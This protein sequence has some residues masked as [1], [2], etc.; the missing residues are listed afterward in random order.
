M[1]CAFFHAQVGAGD[2]SKSGGGGLDIAN[3]LKPALA[4]GDFQVNIQTLVLNLC[5][6]MV[7]KT[8]C[9]PSLSLFWIL[10]ALRA[11]AVMCIALLEPLKRKEKTPLVV[12]MT[13]PA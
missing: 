11:S 12:T 3:M 7:V 5:T 6:Y 9:I 10:A 1:F 8:L 13:Q 4:R 2:T